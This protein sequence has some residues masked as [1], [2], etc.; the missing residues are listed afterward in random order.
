MARHSPHNMPTPSAPQIDKAPRS[1]A[2]P[3][4]RSLRPEQWTK[5]LILFGGLLFGMRLFD[6]AGRRARHRRV[7]HLLRPVRCRLSRQRH[8][9]PRRPTSGI[10]SSAIARSRPARCR[11]ATAKLAARRDRRRRARRRPGCSAG[12]SSTSALAYLVSA[13]VLFGSAQAHGDHRRAHHRV[14]LRAAR[15]GWRR[16]DQRPDQPLAAARHGAAR[17]VPRA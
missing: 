13:D 2:W 6:A 16:G 9:G 3:L 1:T 10:R 14:R 11:R 17:A 7:L 8:H 15:G 4:L 5:N 12:P